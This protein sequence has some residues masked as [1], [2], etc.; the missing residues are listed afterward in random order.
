MSFTRR[1]ILTETEEEFLQKCALGRICTIDRDRYPH[2]VR[3]DYVY[4]DGEVYIAS[5]I[6]RMWHSNIVANQRVAFEVDLYER[7]ADGSIDWRGLMIKGEAQRVQESKDID[8]GVKLLKNKH[9]SAPFGESPILVRIVARRR[10]RWGPWGKFVRQ[11]QN[12]PK[13]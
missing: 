8:K 4:H 9:P 13:D 7:R 1:P 5:P 11:N 6:V 12:P 10:Y 2:C 3:V